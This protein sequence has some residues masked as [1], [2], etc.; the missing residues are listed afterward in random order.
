MLVNSYVHKTRHYRKHYRP[1]GRWY[2]ERPLLR[3][4]DRN[5]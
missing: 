5:P 3:W 1:S 2:S 4:A